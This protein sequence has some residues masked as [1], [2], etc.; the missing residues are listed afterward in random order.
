MSQVYIF[1]DIEHWTPFFKNVFELWSVLRH[2]PP[3]APFSLLMFI[4][5]LAGLWLQQNFHNLQS[6]Y[7]LYHL[8]S[9]T[10]QISNKTNCRNP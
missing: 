6:F 4:Q 10:I 9:G 8:K 3:P 2:P 1:L 5:I 7:I